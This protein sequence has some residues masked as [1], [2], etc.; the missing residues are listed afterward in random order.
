VASLVSSGDFKP[1]DQ[2]WEVKKD[3]TFQID[4]ELEKFE[5]IKTIDIPNLN[6]MVLDKKIEIIHL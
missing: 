1:I 4:K 3:L 2:A 5:K 6:K